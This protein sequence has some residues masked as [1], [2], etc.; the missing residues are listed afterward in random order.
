MF[1]VTV[2][3]ILLKCQVQETLK[4]LT[5]HSLHVIVKMT[6]FQSSPRAGCPRL[7]FGAWTSH[8][9]A[10]LPLPHSC[11]APLFL[12]TA[13]STHLPAS[14]RHCHPLGESFPELATPIPMTFLGFSASSGHWALY[15]NHRE[16]VPSSFPDASSS[17][18]RESARFVFIGSGHL[19]NGFALSRHLIN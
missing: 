11:A 13:A 12:L 1:K 19:A 14:S 6:Q 17:E 5:P 9:H 10:L 15:S 7:L 8:C 2:G 4:K 18:G 16:P 3:L